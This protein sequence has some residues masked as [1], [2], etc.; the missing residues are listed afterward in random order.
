[1]PE[2]VWYFLPDFAHFFHITILSQ[3][4]MTNVKNEQYKQHVLTSI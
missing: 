2:K 1:M 3:H 4:V